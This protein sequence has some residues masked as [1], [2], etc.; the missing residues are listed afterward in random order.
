MGSRILTML[1]FDERNQHN[2]K[3]YKVLI[4]NLLDNFVKNKASIK[5]LQK[6]L[7]KIDKI[8][9]HSSQQLDEQQ[10]N[11]LEEM[12]KNRVEEI[13]QEHLNMMTDEEKEEL[14]QELG[15]DLTSSQN[16]NNED[17]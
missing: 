17:D 2:L 16:D 7:A 6:C 15:I 13:Q 11:E 5:Y 10:L 4:N 14:E 3:Q 12:R 8:E 9:T 1:E